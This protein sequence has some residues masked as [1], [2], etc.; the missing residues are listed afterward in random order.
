RLV[1]NKSTQVWQVVSEIAKSHSKSAAIVLLP[2]LSIFSNINAWADPAQNALP[3]GGQV[4]SGQSTITQNAN[5]LN[6]VQGTQKSIINW[7][8]YNIG[9]NA[10]V[11]YQQTNDSAI[12]LNRVTSGNPSEIFGKLN[13][14]GQVWLINPNGVL[15]GKSAQVNVG[16]IV[17]STLNIADEDFLNGKY[18][19]TGNAGSVVNMGSIVASN[20]GY[21]AM[22]APEV[23]NEGVISAMQGTV[24]MA[25][26]NAITLDFNGN[27]L[28]NVQVDSASVNTLVENKHLIQVGNGQ[29]LM[30]AKAAN[31]LIT[32]VINNSGKIEANSMINDGGVIRLAGAKTVINSGEIS[33]NS[34]SQKGG[35]VHLLGDHVGV[36]D[37][38]S[39]DVSGK[40]GGGTILVG[41]DYQGKNANIQNATKTFIDQAATLTA[42]ATETGD[43]GRVIVWADDVAR[44]YGSVSAKG[45]ATSGNGGFVEISGKRLLNFLGNV[46]LSAA[47]GV[48]GNLLLD[49]LNITLSNNDTNTLGFTAGSDN[50]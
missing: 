43:G 8:T 49:P 34:A 9:A 37:T 29:V 18:Q 35:T 22:L 41:G 38:G 25:A 45:G 1:F 36:F 10:Q 50:T 4:V 39:I 46:D 27:G 47:N 30:S 21:V 24:A 16:G 26:G 28:I 3:T 42:D 48:G 44:Y 19:F 23:R 7:N 14:N 40:N 11:N 13:A 6:I 5:Q 31:G 32:S 2:I 20:G 12:S 33:A 15:F 17:A